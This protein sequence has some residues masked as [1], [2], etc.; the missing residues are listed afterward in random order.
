MLAFR[1]DTTFEGL[2]SAVFDAYSRKKF[3][4]LLLAPEEIPPLTTTEIHTVATSRSKA[5]RVFTGLCKRLTRE[6]KNTVLLTFLADEAET[7]TLIFRYI[8]KQFNAPQGVSIEGDFFD[9]D[10][11]AIDRTAKRVNAE[12][13]HLLGFARFQ[14]TAE[15][16]YF[17]AIAPRHN[18][19][20]LMLPHFIDR[21]SGHPWIL[22][23]LRRSFGFYH[24]D[25]KI[26]EMSLT[27]E[28]PDSGMLPDHLLAEDEKIFQTIWRQYLR[29][30]TI[31]ERANLRLQARCLPR[32]FWPHMIE[33]Q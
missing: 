2:L 20:S 5:D 15:D 23:D 10:V 18:I 26:S 1:Y 9:K 17:S 28:F 12:V 24:K 32:R 8:C 13:C 21:F 4:E 33:M 19:L 25:G 7:P 22:Y 3:P 11:L 27:G 6:G 31:M 14:K 29:A 16:I 30:A